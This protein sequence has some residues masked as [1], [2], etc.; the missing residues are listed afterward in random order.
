MR[1]GTEK[2]SYLGRWEGD[3]HTLSII[4][5]PLLLPDVWLSYIIKQMCAFAVI[6]ICKN[7]IIFSHKPYGKGFGLKFVPKSEIWDVVGMKDRVRSAIYYK[8]YISSLSTPI[9]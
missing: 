3:K 1:Q 5:S 2:L 9:F 8:V 7:P 6:L 4:H